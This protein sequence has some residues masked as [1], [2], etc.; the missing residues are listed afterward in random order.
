VPYRC[1]S[2]RHPGECREYA[3]HL[4]FARTMA[5]LE[6]LGKDT[7]MLMVLT[8]PKG[9]HKTNEEA[10]KAI[11]PMWSAVAERLKR[12]WGEHLGYRTVKRK[13][14]TRHGEVREGTEQREVKRSLPYVATVEVHASGVPH[15]N[16]VLSSEQLRN[17]LGRFAFVERTKGRDAGKRF[18]SPVTPEG[19][20]TVRELKSMVMAAGFGFMVT[21]SPVE[22]LEKVANYV[23]KTASSGGGAIL[24]MSAGE[25]LKSTQLPTNAPPHTRRTRTSRW[26]LPKEISSGLWDADLELEPLPAVK[27]SRSVA[28]LRSLLA[29]AD[30]AKR[31]WDQLLA[32]YASE[33]LPQWKIELLMG[34][35]TPEANVRRVRARLARLEVVS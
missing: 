27:V 32:R 12:K 25:I 17:D 2:W 18:R 14:K 16:I 4:L 6:K 22:S 34:P 35:F 5:G 19:R 3:R 7:L 15:M 21:V 23:T 8:L 30:E 11:G 24:G 10:F 9:S 29:Y 26:A 31:D 33:G 20:A 28:L 1:K 13:Y